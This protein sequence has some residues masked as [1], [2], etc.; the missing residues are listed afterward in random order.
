MYRV[1]LGWSKD[2]K[3]DIAEATRLAESA[4]QLDAHNARASATFGHLSAY[5]KRDYEA[6]LH[7]LHNATTSCPNDP[8]CWALSSATSSYIGRSAEAI[9]KAERALRL[10]PFD[11]F[12]FYY[13]AVLALAYYVA[14]RYE[15]AV[16][17]GRTAMSENEAFTPNLRYLAAALAAS[18]ELNQARD[19][20]DL[21]MQKHP[22]FTLRQ[23]AE[24]V[25]PFRDAT[26][27]QAHL[28][29]LRAAQLPER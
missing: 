21:L 11:K 9:S 26:Q 5:F 22:N 16:K 29:H 12:R 18:G 10:S 25:L 28:D 23:Y 13:I 27:R 17:W 4:L 24:A 20:A 15:D 1:A 14:G 19:V 6:A 7:Y 3:W 2:D 8:F